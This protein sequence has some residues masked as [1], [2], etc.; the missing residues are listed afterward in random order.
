[1]IA[2]GIQPRTT[3]TIRY[4]DNERPSSDH[5]NG[6]RSFW[7]PRLDGIHSVWRRASTN[8]FIVSW[9]SREHQDVGLKQANLRSLRVCHEQQASAS[10]LLIGLPHHGPNHHLRSRSIFKVLSA[11]KNAGLRVEKDPVQS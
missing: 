5:D 4:S 7:G 1:V 2:N 9:S 11:H 8:A 6:E 10:R 3:G